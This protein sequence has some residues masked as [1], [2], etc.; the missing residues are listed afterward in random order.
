MKKVS[1]SICFAMK[2][3]KNRTNF[4]GVNRLKM[5][6][7]YF[8]IN[9]VNSNKEDRE[10]LTFLYYTEIKRLTERKPKVPN[11]LNWYLRQ[12]QRESFDTYISVI[13]PTREAKMD[14]SKFFYSF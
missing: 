13:F 3:E 12:M 6:T 4:T 14:G 9:M 1:T 10:T 7:Q 5:S 2:I 8:D 11:S